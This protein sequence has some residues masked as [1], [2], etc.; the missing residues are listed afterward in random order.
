MNFLKFE[1][2]GNVFVNF[3]ELWNSKWSQDT[4]NGYFFQNKKYI[5]NQIQLPK[6]IKFGYNKKV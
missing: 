2:H 3:Q 1:I 6:S 4:C 5:N